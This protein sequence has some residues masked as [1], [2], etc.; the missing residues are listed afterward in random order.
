MGLAAP[1]LTPL[2]PAEINPGVSATRSP[3]AE[4]TIRAADGS[5]DAPSRTGWAP[6][7]SAATS[8]RACVYGARTS[9]DGRHRGG[10]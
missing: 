2:D 9:L 10:R 8:T 1:L 7:R 3:G 5:E 4:Q 6:T